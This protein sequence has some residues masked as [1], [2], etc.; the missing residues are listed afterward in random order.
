MKKNNSLLVI[1]MA[2]LAISALTSLALAANDGIAASPK[3]RAAIDEYKA[4]QKVVA[5]MPAPLAQMPC[6][7]CKDSVVTRVDYSARG[8]HKPV[9]SVPVHL[10]PD[11]GTDWKITGTG[12]ARQSVATHVCMANSTSA[13]ACC[14]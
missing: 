14:K 4:S 6:P 1:A 11:C 9:I 13:M 8:A 7:K 5:A 3:V 12:R 2:G 10:C